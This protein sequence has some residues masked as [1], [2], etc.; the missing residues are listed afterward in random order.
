MV[1]IS[2]SPVG[3]FLRII[4]YILEVLCYIK[5]YKGNLKQN[6]SINGHNTRSKL[7][8]H[9]E[10][11]NTVLFQKSVV[12]MGIKLYNKMPESFKKKDDFQ[13]FNKGI[14]SLLLSHSCYSVDDFLQF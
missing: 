12:N 10:F 11:C 7:N 13:L 4:S 8:F 3:K 9:V 1:Q 6:Q 14:K 5:S 2:L